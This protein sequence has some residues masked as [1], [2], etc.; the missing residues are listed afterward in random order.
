VADFLSPDSFCDS[1]EEFAR[2]ALE[3]HHARRFRRLAVDAATC[4]EH[5][6]KACLARRSPA[7]LTELRSEANFASLLRLLGLT[8]GRPLRLTDGKPPRQLRTVGLRDALDR[9]K[10]FVQ[11]QAPDPDLKTLVDVRDG[12]V[13]AAQ[14]EELEERLVVA[15]VLHADAFLADLGRDRAEFWGGHL[16]VV[17]ALVTEAA[18]RTARE[19]A[20][21]I[22]GARADLG[23]RYD[24]APAEVLQLVRQLAGAAKLDSGERRQECP[25]CESP[26]VAWGD[27]EVDWDYERDAQGRHRATRGKVW[28]N[29]SDFR[30]EICGLHLDDEAEFA[31]AGLEPRWLVPGADPYDYDPGFDEELYYEALEEERRRREEEEWWHHSG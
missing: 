4:L 7:L 10:A 27:H 12:T 6:A 2:S 23:R 22:A 29:A 11:S 8:D 24:D 25:A 30:C 28:F 20:V 21:R 15:F 3:A 1:A 31:A 17:D 26:G 19:V 13:H 9:V 5:L 18:D 16:G 14:S